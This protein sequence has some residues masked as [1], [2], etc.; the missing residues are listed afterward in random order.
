[1]YKYV[2]LS[3]LGC[4]RFSILRGNRTITE[5]ILSL[6]VEKN[7][8]EPTVYKIGVGPRKTMFSC[9]FPTFLAFDFT[10]I[11]RFYTVVPFY[12][13]RG[14]LYYKHNFRCCS[15]HPPPPLPPSISRIR[16]WNWRTILLQVIEC[17]SLSFLKCLIFS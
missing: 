13:C 2:P 12:Y 7:N 6:V 15:G 4:L 1:M 5:A 3:H 14:F 10:V 16:P 8:R 11:S 17:Y 9:L